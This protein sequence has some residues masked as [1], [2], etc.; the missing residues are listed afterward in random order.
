VRPDAAASDVLE[1]LVRADVD[2]VPV[3]DN[4]HVQGPVSRRHVMQVL[5][6]R[7]ELHA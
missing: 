7:A 4:G 6:T 1:L 3:V 5:Q 2:Q